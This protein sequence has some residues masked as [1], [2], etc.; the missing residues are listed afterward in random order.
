MVPPEVIGMSTSDSPFQTPRSSRGRGP[1]GDDDAGNDDG[2][3]R[4]RPRCPPQMPQGENTT[5]R[6]LT[7]EGYRVPNPP[8]PM[9]G[10]AVFV[11]ITNGVR[12]TSFSICSVATSRNQG[13]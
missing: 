6:R 1:G 5:A 11:D 13:A 2:F 7:N 4:P 9:D 8:H 12:N 3:G 10:G